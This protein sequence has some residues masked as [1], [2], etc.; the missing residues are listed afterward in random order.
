MQDLSLRSI[1]ITLASLIPFIKVFT[2]YCRVHISESFAM[3]VGSMLIYLC[4]IL[5]LF[6]ILQTKKYFNDYLKIVFRI[7]VIY[8]VLFF[9]QI[10]L[11]PSTTQV[12]QHISTFV[13]I[14]IGAF[15][16]G[17]AL[18]DIPLYIKKVGVISIILE[19]I[20][21]TEPITNTLLSEDNMVLG[22]TL[23]PICIYGLLYS[24]LY[25][26]KLVK[27]LAF[28]SCLPV[29]LFTSRGCG[30]SILMFYL[31][32]LVWNKSLSKKC[33]IAIGVLSLIVVWLATTYLAGTGIDTSS[34]SVVGKLTNGML[35]DNN[36]RDY[37]LELG[38][39]IVVENPWNGIG[40]DGDIDLLG[41]IVDNYPFIHNVIVE[42]FMDFGIPVALLL[43][44]LYF[45]PI[46]KLIRTWGPGYQTLFIIALLCSVW[47]RLFFSD[48]Y[49]NNMYNIMFLFGVVLGISREKQVSI[50]K[51]QI[52]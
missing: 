19:L 16:V 29:I 47:I 15:T 44:Y 49:V 24:S 32:S 40:I 37:L 39:A 9:L 42:L 10:T 7:F 12:Y 43:I 36:G 34:G 30:L 35:T 3:T 46:Y 6:L 21:I 14:G 17:Y 23:A 51:Q 11:T 38:M 28:I 20:F 31:I 25:G 45:K 5:A 33:G 8:V 22:Y 41:K 48:S 27:Y 50:V 4:I 18:N 13:F 2:Q 1:Y 52:I 26:S